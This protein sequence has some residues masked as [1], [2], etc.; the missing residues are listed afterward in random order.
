[1]FY[2][3]QCFPDM[4]KK[5]GILGGTFNPPHIGHLYMA[6]AALSEG[7]L[8]EVLWL[9]NGDPPHKRPEVSA[10]DR[11]RMTNLTIEGE[12]DMRICDLE[13]LRQGRSYMAET[14]EQLKAIYPDDRFALICGADMLAGMS[15][16]YRARRVFELAEIFVFDRTE[17]SLDPFIPDLK[18]MADFLREQ[19]A[20]VS[21]LSARIP[22]ISSTKIRTLAAKA[23][24]DRNAADEL[25]RLVTKK[26]A[27]YILA[28]H[29]YLRMPE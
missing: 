9:P 14:L 7:D 1:M 16:W 26:T 22:D 23:A 20:E 4:M 19:G 2:I 12:P 18:E 15:S 25:N 27:D 11:L 21:V 29:L 5:I 3:G 8:D 6:R 24:D 17:K 28:E 13:I 10:E